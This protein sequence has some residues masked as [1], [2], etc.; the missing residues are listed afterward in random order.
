MTEDDY[1]WLLDFQDGVC[2]I[3][4]RKPKA[5][6]KRMAVDHDHRTGRVRGLLCIRCNRMLG[7]YNEDQMLFLNAYA[8]LI[9][10]ITGAIEGWTH[11]DAPPTKER[12]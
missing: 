2:A 12:P 4:S 8:Y 6:G 1:A 3:C 7:Y 9:S 10:P 11:R 5:G